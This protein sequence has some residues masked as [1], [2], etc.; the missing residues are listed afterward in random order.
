MSKRIKPNSEWKML[1]KISSKA[2]PNNV[3]IHLAE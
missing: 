3:E 1:E 2:C